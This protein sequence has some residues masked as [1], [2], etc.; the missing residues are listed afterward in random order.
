M[1]CLRKDCDKEGAFR[2]VLILRV[3]PHHTPAEAMLD[4]PLCGEHA[5]KTTVDDLVSEGGWDAI[6]SQVTSIGRGKPKRE[7]TVVRMDRIKE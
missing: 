2:P 4:L 7:L 6:C 5:M 3:H 1:N